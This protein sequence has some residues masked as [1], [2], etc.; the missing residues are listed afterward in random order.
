MASNMTIRLFEKAAHASEYSLYRPTYSRSVLNTILDYIS[1]KG[2]DFNLAIDIACGSG[3][4]T[5]YLR[6]AFKECI[7]VDISKEQIKQAQLQ[8]QNLSTSNVKFQ[9]ADGTNLPVTDKCANLITIATA[10]HW[11]MEKDKLYS[12][13]KRV[14]RDKGCLAVYTYGLFHLKDEKVNMLVKNFTDKL[15]DCW[16]EE[17]KHVEMKYRNIKL[18]FACVEYVETSMVWRNSLTGLMGFLSSLSAYKEY[19]KRNPA[20][21]SKQLEELRNALEKRLDDV[22]NDSSTGKTSSCTHSL[23]AHFPVY[24][25]LG[26]N[27]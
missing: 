15:S 7:G 20:S 12:E 16:H 6:D 19:C 17:V 8:C 23:D 2:G 25:W 24:I 27:V 3:Q 18:P 4:S 14:L 11:I 26:Q 21:G 9:E 1:R 10:W 13:C 5:F 22:S